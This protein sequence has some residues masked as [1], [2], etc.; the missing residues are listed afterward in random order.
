MIVAGWKESNAIH[1]RGSR[2]LCGSFFWADLHARQVEALDADVGVLLLHVLEHR[3]LALLLVVVEHRL[4]DGH[5]VDAAQFVPCRFLVLGGDL[6][7]EL[8]LVVGLFERLEPQ[9]AA[10]ALHAQFAR[11]ELEKRLGLVHHLTREKSGRG[12]GGGEENEGSKSDP[13]KNA[14]AHLCP[15]GVVRVEGKGSAE[16]EKVDGPVGVGVW[17]CGRG[18]TD[19]RTRQRTL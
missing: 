6:P 4:G 15:G 13:C 2:I 7:R 11:Q 5:V 19:A 14:C 9:A 18:G 8:D 3:A 12:E 17:M 16:A 10:A 1:S